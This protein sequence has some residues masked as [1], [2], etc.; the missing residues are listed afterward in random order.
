[1]AIEAELRFLVLL[2]AVLSGIVHDRTTGQPLVGVSIRVDGKQAV[3]DNDGRYSVK[4]VHPGAHTLTLGS[5]DVP[6]QRFH[7][8]VKA[9]STRF[10]MRACSATLD[11]NCSGLPAGLQNG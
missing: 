1:M 3:T 8:T 7:V 10:D 4:G 5:K 6:S 9:P 11:Y 2:L